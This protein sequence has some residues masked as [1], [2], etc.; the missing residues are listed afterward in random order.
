MDGVSALGYTIELIK[1][2]PEGNEDVVKHI[3]KMQM[4]HQK[5]RDAYREL[6]SIR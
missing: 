5:M 2:D 4:A 6:F 3:P 1:R